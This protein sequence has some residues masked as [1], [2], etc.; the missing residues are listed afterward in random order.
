MRAR[1][2][3]AAVA[4]LVC[5]CVAGVAPV[6]AKTIPACKAGQ[7]S[8]VKKPC[9]ASKAAPAAKSVPHWC[10]IVGATGNLG[11]NTGRAGGVAQTDGAIGSVSLDCTF[12]AD[13]LTIQIPGHT[14]LS[15]TPTLAG[16]TC[17]PNGDTVTCKLNVALQKQGLTIA[18]GWQNLI[19]WKL[20]P[21]DPASNDVTN[22]SCGLTVVLTLTNAGATTYTKNAITACEFSAGD[23]LR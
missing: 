6:A 14:F 19:N 12:T 10:P 7:K 18:G 21:S 3:L 16:D 8:T 15:A 1:L 17:S 23:L 13:G 11:G 20:T 2:A 5:W 9:A 4:A 22:G